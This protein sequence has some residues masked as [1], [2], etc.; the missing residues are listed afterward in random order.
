MFIRIDTQK[1]EK[2]KNK[3]NNIYLGEIEGKD[4]LRFMYVTEPASDFSFIQA[5]FTASLS[6][7]PS[8][9]FFMEGLIGGH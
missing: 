3:I 5:T 9:H 7:R 1:I 4:I 8:F 2:K 6:Q